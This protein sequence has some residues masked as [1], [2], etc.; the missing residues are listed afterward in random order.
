MS[1]RVANLPCRIACFALALFPCA[2]S[3]AA[4][5]G[6]FSGKVVVELLDGVES[7]HQLKLTEDFA[8]RDPAGKEW[9]ARR[10]GVLDGRS[11]P[12]EVRPYLPFTDP[13]RKAVVI[14]DYYTRAKTEPWLDTHRM[15]YSANVAEGLNR[16]QAKVLHMALHAGGWRW[17]VPT[18]TC[19]RTCHTSANVL[20]WK[21]VTREEEVKK[22]AEWIWQADPPLADIER[23][24]DAVIAKPGPH[25]FGQ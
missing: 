25:I 5:Q 19:F 1:L 10:D 18:S 6:E 8:F 15:F 20:A 14:H 11:M 3:F 22:L 7:D 23:R 24:V 12:P 13:L 16:L 17:E 4:E 9:R 2:A 21:P